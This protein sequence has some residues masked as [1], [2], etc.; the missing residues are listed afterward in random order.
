MNTVDGIDGSKFLIDPASSD[1]LLLARFRQYPEFAEEI[2]FD[3]YTAIRYIILMYDMGNSEVQAL[4]PDYMTRKRNCA[5]MAGFDVKKGKFEEDVETALIGANVEF[6]AMIVRYVRMFNNP[7][8]V[9]YV[10]FYEMLIKNVH[11][12]IQTTDA[13][14]MTTIRTNI[15]NL[16]DMISDVTRNIFRGDDS[17]GLVK[18]LYATMEEEKL[19]LRPELMSVAILNRDIMFDKRADAH[20]TIA[21][22]DD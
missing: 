6:N 5:L 7:D 16:R 20:K 21:E 13:K 2:P 9:S 22:I 12:S 4:F 3:R 8:Y 17:V 10:S 19:K 14:E 11:L 15:S 18:Q 1:D